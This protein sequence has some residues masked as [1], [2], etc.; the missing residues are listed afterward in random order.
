MK[1]FIGSA[2]GLA[3]FAAWLYQWGFIFQTAS[4]FPALWVGFTVLLQF[5]PFGGLLGVCNFLFS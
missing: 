2:L 3:Y 5:T 1:T 4:E